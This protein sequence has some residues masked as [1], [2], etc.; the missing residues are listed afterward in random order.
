[1][2][3]RNLDLRSA[4]FQKA[5]EVG[6]AYQLRTKVEY[7]PC[8]NNLNVC[9]CY[10][11]IKAATQ[12]NASCTCTSYKYRVTNS[13][14]HIEIRNM[15]EDPDIMAVSLKYNACTLT[16]FLA[17]GVG[18]GLLSPPPPLQSLYVVYASMH[19]S[20]PYPG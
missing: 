9:M 10:M 2:Y 12:R 5:I 17:W 18:E 14:D 4:I 1:M 16:E 7:L 11:Y 8:S 19:S 20:S 3:A 15:Q 13:H 6:E